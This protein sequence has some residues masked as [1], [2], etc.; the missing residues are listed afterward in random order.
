MTTYI[1]L[2]GVYIITIYC[3]YRF[4]YSHASSDMWS[5]I[6]RAFIKTSKCSAQDFAVCILE[7]SKK[8]G[9]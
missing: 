7:I 8:E 2:F 3:S 9:K 5:V 1:L 6:Q 4:G